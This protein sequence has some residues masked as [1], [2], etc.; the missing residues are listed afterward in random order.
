MMIF[1][2]G[3]FD[4]MV[5]P[6]GALVGPEMEGLFV[7]SLLDDHLGGFFAAT[8]SALRERV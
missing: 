4:E 8:A 6:L 5:E 2:L 7:T 3:F 1:F